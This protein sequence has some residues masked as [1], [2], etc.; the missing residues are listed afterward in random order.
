MLTSLHMGHNLGKSIT[1]EL[2]YVLWDIT[3]AATVFEGEGFS[4]TAIVRAS[5]VI[6]PSVQ[7]QCFLRVS[8]LIKEA[9]AF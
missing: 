2:Q 4:S 9:S 7:E 5:Q 8:S 3:K 6:Q 1:L